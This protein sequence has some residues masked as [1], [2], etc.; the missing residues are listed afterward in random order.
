MRVDKSRPL[1][2]GLFDSIHQGGFGVNNLG[3]FA[4]LDGLEDDRVDFAVLGEFAEQHSEVL[5]AIYDC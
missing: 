4:R 2:V 3:G 1:L 5:T